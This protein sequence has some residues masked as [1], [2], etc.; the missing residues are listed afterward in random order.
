MN[1]SPGNEAFGTGRVGSS[2]RTRNSTSH[3]PSISIRTCPVPGGGGGRTGAGPSSDRP[4]QAARNAT[5]TRR[6]AIGRMAPPV[7]PAARAVTP[8]DGITPR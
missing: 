2:T 5:A 1:D 4:R 8:A 6:M 3:R 7:A